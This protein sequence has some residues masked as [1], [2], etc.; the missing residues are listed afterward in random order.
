MLNGG[1]DNAQND[2]ILRVG[3]SI[4]SPEGQEYRVLDLL[5]KG[6]F[7]QVA[8][9]QP[10]GQSQKLALK[11]VKNRPAYK[12][13]GVVEVRILHLLR[14]ARFP[15]AY[16]EHAVRMLDFFIFRSH[17]CIVFELL[18]A[19]L[20]ELLKQNQQHGLTL[21]SVRL[22][23]EQLLEAMVLMRQAGIIHCDMK[24]E[25][26]LLTRQLT[27]SV[28]LIDF[29]SACF[30]RHTV[31]SYIQSR[32]YRAP[33]VLLGLTPYDSA[34]DM[35]SLGCICAELIVGHPLFPG[36]SQFDQLRRIFQTLGQDSRPLHYSAASLPTSLLDRCKHRDRYLVPHE[37]RLKSLD[38]LRAAGENVPD[39]TIYGFEMTSLQGLA[40]PRY[41][42]TLFG[43]DLR[44]KLLQDTIGGG[45]LD[46]EEHEIS[47][48]ISFLEAVL[49]ID[50]AER[51]TPQEALMHPFF[52]RPGARF[53]APS[54][55]GP[56]PT[57]PRR[58]GLPGS[59][60]SNIN[61]FKPPPSDAPLFQQAAPQ[62]LYSY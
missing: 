54:S 56:A 15:P 48:L 33:E 4:F 29:G 57:S 25:N 32:Y 55:A 58:T 31:F 22:L 42:H 41:K 3:E 10:A 60:P 51:P 59:C 53:P 30:D 38:E 49:K 50:P 36:N 6:T 2:Y 43:T 20:Y 45:Q 17:L 5:G 46:E 21:S 14:A 44:A 47:L 9:C 13:Q 19:S 39:P 62:Y 1:Y 35:W 40:K 27:P 24:P 16:Q 23:T 61:Y 34:I 11:V 8:K 26:V 28:K 37:A 7:G 18:G 52:K 12:H